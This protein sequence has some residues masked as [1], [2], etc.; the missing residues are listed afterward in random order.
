MALIS[1][2]NYIHIYVEAATLVKHNANQETPGTERNLSCPAPFFFNV[3]PQCF[4]KLNVNTEEV[5]DGRPLG[6]R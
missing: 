6:C 3:K 1:N 2:L 5:G 4:N